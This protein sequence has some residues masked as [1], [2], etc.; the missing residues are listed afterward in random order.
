MKIIQTFWSKPLF[1]SNQN[2]CQNRY[3]GGWLNYRYFLLSMAYSCL[4]ISRHYPHL[5]LYTDTFG[6]SLFKDI[7]QLPYYRYHTILDDLSEVDEAFWAFAKV[8]TYSVQNEPFLH[9]DNDVFIWHPF[10]QNII[11][12]DVACQ[13]IENIDEFSL[14]DYHLALDY[15]RKNV[16]SAPNIIRDS[17]CNIAYNM[18][19]F[20]G[21][22]INFI[23]QYSKQAVTC[24]NSMYDAILHSGN[25]KGKFN[26]VFEQLLLK[27]FAQNY[28][29][30]VS[31]LVPN[32]EIDEI[33]KFSTI[34][35]AQYESKYTHCIGQLKKVTYICE[36]IEFRMKYDFP[37]Y[38]KRIMS[39]LDTEQYVF[40]ENTKSMADYL[41]FCKIY[42]KINHAVDINDIMTNYEFILN[43]DCWIEEKDGGHYLNTPKEKSKLTD[44]RLLLTYF[45]LKTTGMN[46]C[47]IISNEKD[48]IKLSFEE[49]VTNVFHLIMESLYITKCLTVA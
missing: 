48:T 4:T 20:G 16:N 49:I 47:K 37:S 28:Q 23:Q 15:I 19:V 3:Q 31:F 45:E 36:Q 33:L 8:K 5:E 26:V 12:A 22:D 32:S 35:T 38:Y 1:H 30:K 7:L 39:Y 44:W 13:S 24:F 40:E 6:K 18:G 46:I 11:S 10:P 29:E 14:T 27:E 43:N 34:E 41:N 21:N 17:R 42:S 2:V 9:V 25:L